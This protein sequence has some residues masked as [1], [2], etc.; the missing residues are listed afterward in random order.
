M[1]GKPLTGGWGPWSLRVRSDAQTTCDDGH[2]RCTRLLGT[3]IVLVVVSSA[4]VVRTSLAGTTCP[5][6]LVPAFTDEWGSGETLSPEAPPED[7]SLDYEDLRGPLDMDGDGVADTRTAADGQSVTIERGDGTLILEHTGGLVAE[8]DPRHYG[9]FD[10]DG[11]SELIVLRYEGDSLDAKYVIPGTTTPGTHD[12]VDVGI[13]LE[14]SEPEMTSVSDTVGDQDGDGADDLLVAPIIHSG[15]DVMASGPG[16]TFDTSS[17]GLGTIDAWVLGLIVLDEEGP[18]VLVSGH[19]E[20]D[21]VALFELAAEPP[22]S[23]RTAE[24][25]APAGSDLPLG[26]PPGAFQAS[27][28]RSGEHRWISVMASDR[29]TNRVWMWDLDACDGTTTPTSATEVTDATPAP[30]QPIEPVYTG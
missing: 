21:T 27:G 23:L 20:S 29:S 28:F 15:S 30:P 16:A 6:P 11:R 13:R 1:S 8:S 12:V 17:P 14:S 9:D 19:T 18:P 25:D 22:V 24:V 3:G 26:L 7:E 5:Q 2:V 10:G 4:L